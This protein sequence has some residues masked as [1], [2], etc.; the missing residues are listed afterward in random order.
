QALSADSSLRVLALGGEP[1]PAPSVLRS[2]RG[3]GNSTR[4]YNLYGTTEVSCWATCHQLHLD[5]MSSEAVPLGSALMD[6]LVELRDEDGKKIAQGE[7]QVFIGGQDRVCFLGEEVLAAK[8]TMRGTGDWAE[9]RDGHLYYLGRRDRLVKR[10]G[11]QLHLDA[12]H[13]MVQSL[14]QVQMC[15][16][17][18]SQAQRL[19]AF[20]V[21]SSCA[22][23]APSCGKVRREI[24]GGLSQVL[25]A[26]SMPDSII[27]LPALPL[28]AHGKVNMADLLQEY[29]RQRVL[30]ISHDALGD[31]DTLRELLQKLWREALSL[32]DDDAPVAM[33]SHFLLSGETHSAPYVSVMTS[34]WHWAWLCQGYWRSSSVAP[35]PTS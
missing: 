30:L 35:S 21:P 31:W 34:L 8:G 20:V 24:I 5:T 29:E 32:D 3:E 19:V 13:K 1:C 26:Y 25:P 9:L 28:T 11:Q 15:A 6:T 10:H 27:L 2:W 12:L 14:P 17:T 33:D 7:G 4:I 18:L 23:S 22:D 16:V